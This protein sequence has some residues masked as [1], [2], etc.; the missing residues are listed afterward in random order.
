MSDSFACLNYIFTRHQLERYLLKQLDVLATEG[1]PVMRPL[2]FDFPHDDEPTMA[3]ADQF[4]FGD[5]YMVAPVL[6]A[7]ATERLVLFP[8]GASVSFTHMFTGE[9]FHG[10][11]GSVSVAVN[12]ANTS[13]FP[14]F[15]ITRAVKE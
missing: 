8:G 6:Q 1:L 9:V 12:A 11:Q 7:G 2:F 13:E 15:R 10:G 5:E 4:L 3:V 14:F